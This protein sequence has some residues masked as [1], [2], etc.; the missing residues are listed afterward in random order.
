L[1]LEDFL[2]LCLE[3]AFFLRSSIKEKIP[4]FGSFIGKL[5]KRKKI[6][7]KKTRFKFNLKTLQILHYWKQI[8][9][10]QKFLWIS[11]RGWRVVFP[12]KLKISGQ[13]SKKAGFFKNLSRSLIKF[14]GRQKNCKKKMP[15][16][17]I[18]IF[19]KYIKNKNFNLF[20]K[21]YLKT[22]LGCKFY[23]AY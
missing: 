20:K 2:L 13:L 9:F 14:T 21:I 12:K 23:Y 8:L 7:Y 10:K 6:Q 17:R 22:I 11:W 1:V 5:I 4:K 16:S 15:T 19:S 18:L 3:D